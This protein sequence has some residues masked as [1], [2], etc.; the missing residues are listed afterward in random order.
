MITNTV[1]HHRRSLGSDIPPFDILTF[2]KH[3]SR[4]PVES[5]LRLLTD[6]KAEIAWKLAAKERQGDVS[7]G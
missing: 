4:K 3:E 1:T 6:F 7:L 5:N 2:I